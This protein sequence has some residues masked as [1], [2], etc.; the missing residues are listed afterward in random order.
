MCVCVCVTE[1][2]ACSFEIRTILKLDVADFWN[3]NM[4]ITLLLISFFFAI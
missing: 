4:F 2:G 3:N 1:A